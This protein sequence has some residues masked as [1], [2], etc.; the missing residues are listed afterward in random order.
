[1]LMST[2][3]VSTLVSSLLIALMMVGMGCISTGDARRSIEWQVLLTIAA[4]FGVGTA[5][6]KSGAAAAIA[7]FFFNVSGDL[8]PIIALAAVYLLVSLI[9]EVITNNAAAVLMFPIC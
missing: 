1:V 8:S 2:G 3:I 7:R 9:T 6:S 4:A 5:L